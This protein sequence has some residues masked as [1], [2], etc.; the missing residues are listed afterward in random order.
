MTESKTKTRWQYNAELK[1]QILAECARP[2]T[3]VV[4]LALLNGINASAPRT[5]V[6][7]RQRP[8]LTIRCQSGPASSQ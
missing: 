7:R 2:G 4:V 3:S 1:Q 6:D 8:W 5:R